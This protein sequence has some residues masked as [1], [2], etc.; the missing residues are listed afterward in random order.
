MGYRNSRTRA[1]IGEA[2]NFALPTPPSGR[3]GC[4]CS[5]RVGAL[6]QPDVSMVGAQVMKKAAFLTL[7]SLSFGGCIT[8]MGEQ[9]SDPKPV[10]ADSISSIALQ[11]RTVSFIVSCTVG[12]PCWRF[13]RSDYSI[14]GRSVAVTVYAR[15]ISATCPAVVVSIKAPATIVVPFSGSYTFRFW[16]YGGRTLD[17][18]LTIQ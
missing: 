2:C 11:G 5:G 10:S 9:L 18:T 8:D 7:I 12:D 3:I 16:R 13:V 1:G 6:G 14:S 4:V 17:T 15:R